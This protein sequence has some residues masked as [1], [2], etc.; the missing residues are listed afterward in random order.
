[1]GGAAIGALV[2]TCPGRYTWRDRACECLVSF[3][4]SNV[5][6][7][8]SGWTLDDN[9]GIDS[10]WGA[11]TGATDIS[12]GSPVGSCIRVCGNDRSRD[13][14]TAKMHEYSNVLASGEFDMN[15]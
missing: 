14:A 9:V 13:V 1:M 15:E 8:G 11:W 6:P 3:G 5:G 7:D 12:V 2:S 10:Q 4:V